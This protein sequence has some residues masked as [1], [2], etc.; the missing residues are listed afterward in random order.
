VFLEYYSGR[1]F[2]YLV[3]ESDEIFLLAASSMLLSIIIDIIII[4]V[5]I[6]ISSVFLSRQVN[7]SW[8]EFNDYCLFVITNF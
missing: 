4:I 5:I 7:K 1:L 2:L 3:T 8:T 6:N